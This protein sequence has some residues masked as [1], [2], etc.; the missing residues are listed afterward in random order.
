MLARDTNDQKAREMQNK[1]Y[2]LDGEHNVFS[3]GIE[4]RHLFECAV[5]VQYLSQ[6]VKAIKHA[7]ESKL[8]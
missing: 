7:D 4:K 1:R 8:W 2:E 3:F 6:V 5:I